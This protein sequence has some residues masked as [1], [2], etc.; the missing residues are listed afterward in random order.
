MNKSINALLMTIFITILFINCR[1]DR[2]FRI[3]EEEMLIFNQAMQNGEEARLGFEK[4][5]AY[6]HAWLAVSDPETGLI[7]RNLTSGSDIWNAKDAAADNYPFMVLTA[8]FVEPDMMEGRMLDMLNTERRLT[9][10][11]ESLPDTYSFSKRDFAEADVNKAELIFGASEYIKDGLLPLTEWLGISPWSERMEEMLYDMKNEI[12]VA[13]A[14]GKSGY[15][16]A[17]R[18]EVNGELL[19]VLSRIYWM[20]GDPSLLDWAF[21]IAD[22]YL[23][24]NQRPTRD[25]LYLRL[26]DH[27]CELVSGLCE[28]YITSYFADLEKKKIYQKP[29]YEMLD[30][31]LEI[32]RNDD[33]FFYDDINPQTGEIIE[34]RIADTWGYTLNGFYGVYMVDGREEYKEAVLKVFS[35]LHKYRNY[36]WEGGSADGYADA[37]ESALNLYNRIPNPEASDWI[38]S[39][40]RVMWD[41]QREDGIVEGWHGDGNFART[42]IMHNLWK[43]K[44]LYVHPWQNDIKLGAEI[45]GDTLY[46]SVST[47]VPWKGTLHFDK[48]RH[49]SHLNL[50]MD[51][52]RINQFQE[53]FTA[54]PGSSFVLL[55]LDKKTE[56]IVDGEKLITGLEM[57]VTGRRRLKVIEVKPK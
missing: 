6:L 48:I 7:P 18:E 10:R 14:I 16:K 47:E 44:G 34:S 55:D 57:D 21:E 28:I 46:I 3:S 4:C 25:L 51:W 45:R 2:K 5:Q 52:P 37:I 27:G 42:T 8:F 30:R 39:E 31:I 32:G 1:S 17:P 38:D 26:R 24:G 49:G 13:E 50:P 35:N 53:W 56:E 29:L 12:R 22:F 43:S 15:G 33:G 9:S 36:D 40:I 20:T 54:K 19:Q 41:M 11:L 23:L